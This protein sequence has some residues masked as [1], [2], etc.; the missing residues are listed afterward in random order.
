M[1]KSK[2][3]G[4]GGW[5]KVASKSKPGEFYYCNRQTKKCTWTPPPD[6]ED[7]DKVLAHTALVCSIHVCTC[8]YRFLNRPRVC[9]QDIAKSAKNASK[10]KEHQHHQGK[11]KQGESGSI[12]EREKQPARTGKLR[13]PKLNLQ[14]V[15]PVKSNT[16]NNGNVERASSAPP[17]H[18]AAS[19]D[20]HG[21]PG[22]PL[23]SASATYGSGE[24][25]LTRYYS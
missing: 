3:K 15:L 24:T 21:T 22:Q 23:T 20:K 8:V 10:G 25:S 6:F 18:T 2:E 17:S 16:N 7:S 13:P 1:S 14:V 11:E 9:V 5:M 4:S 19:M 12:G